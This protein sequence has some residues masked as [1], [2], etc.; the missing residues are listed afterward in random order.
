MGIDYLNLVF[1]YTNLRPTNI[2]VEN[3]PSSEKLRFIDFEIT[4]YFP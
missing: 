2:I 1:N 3:K 4:S